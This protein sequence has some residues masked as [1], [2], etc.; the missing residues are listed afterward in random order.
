VPI[1]VAGRLWG[2]VVASSSEPYSFPPDTEERV[3]GFAEL[4]ADALANA[5]AQ[6]R[7]AASRA[8]IVQTGEAERRRLERNLHDGA[9]QRLVALALDLRTAEAKLSTDPEAARPL[10]EAAREELALALEELR[11]L[12]HGIHPAILSDRGLG[13]ALEAIAARTPV[14]V[15]LEALPPAR[16]P[17]PVEAGPTTSSPRP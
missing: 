12:A 15:K 3:A 2:A 11:E 6:Q 4:V 9:Q 8:R 7:L 17:E 16:L 1:T 13:P 5:D 14:P 10:L